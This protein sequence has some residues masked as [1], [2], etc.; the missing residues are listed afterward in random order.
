[1]KRS[2]LLLVA[3]ATLCFGQS[4]AQEKQV[5]KKEVRKEVK[6]EEE[7]GVKTLTIRTSEDGKESVEVYKGA[8]ADKKMAE[9]EAQHGKGTEVKE[10]VTVEEVNGQQ[11]VRVKKTVDGQ[12]TE[13]VKETEM[14]DEQHKV[15][16][17]SIHKKQI[18]RV[19]L[20]RN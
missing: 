8:E 5:V 13:E 18:K 10:E 19:E 6:M 4:I 17:E 15:S 9:L 16:P 12:T 20:K 2:F 7:G 3:F 11:V 14:K 1:M